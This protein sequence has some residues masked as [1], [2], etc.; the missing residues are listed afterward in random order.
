MRIRLRAPSGGSLT[1]GAPVLFKS[2]QVGRIENVELT[3][4]GDVAIDA[5]VNAPYHL[6]LTEG[7]RFW[8]ASGFSIQIGAGG[9]SLNVDS[10]ISLLQGGVSFDTVGSSTAPVE[11]GHVYDLYPTESAA[12]QNF[13]DDAPGERLLVDTLFEGSVGGLQPGAP[14]RFRG[15]QV[16]EV[17][18]LHAAIVDRAGQPQ[19]TLRATLSIAPSRI[20]IPEG[21]DDPTAA[22]LD[23]L[24]VQVSHG[25]RATLATSGLLAQSLQVELVELPDAA[26]AGIDRDARAEPADPE[27]ARQPRQRDEL[28]RGRAQARLRACR[29]RRWCRT[30]RP[31]SATSTPS[32][33]TSASARRPRTS[34]RCSPTCAPCS[35]RAAS[36]RR[37][38]SSRRSSPRRARIVDQAVQAQARRRR[39]PPRSRPP[40]AAVA[41]IDGAAEER[42]GARRRDRGGRP[43]GAR[44]AARRSSSTPA[45][46]SSATSTRSCRAT[47]SRSVPASLNASLA[48]LRA[49]IEAL[50][51][52]GAVDNLNATL[53]SARQVTDE[54]AAA[55]L[56]AEPADGDRR[57]RRTPPPTSAPPPTGCPS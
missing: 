35:T 17:E 27:R 23:A 31:C 15:L 26:P 21:A 8:N 53:A 10:L 9:A 40:A 47:R 25:L 49:L 51:T 12:R 34:A 19:V 13:F 14:V 20:G 48:E 50:R 32:S 43:P 57:R 44:A 2:I 54:L 41:S 42:A 39:S 4:A 45:R 52:G 33:P 24:E 56:A 22:A 28:G 37:R 5:F 3:P 55:D 38:P 7:A 16:G 18:A 36:S 6:R 29:S 30:Q 11:P 1:V 46:G